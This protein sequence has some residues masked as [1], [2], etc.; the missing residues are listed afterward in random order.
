MKVL[1]CGLRSTLSAE[2][3]RRQT[4]SPESTEYS[5]LI[6]KYDIQWI[7][8]K[9]EEK[10]K[11]SEDLLAIICCTVSTMPYSLFCM[12]LVSHSIIRIYT[13]EMLK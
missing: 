7:E 6:G 11:V 8:T 1:F 3:R 5:M 13:G 10:R 12:K 2:C 9:T 4:A